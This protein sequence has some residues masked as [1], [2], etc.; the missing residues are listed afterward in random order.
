MTSSNGRTDTKHVGVP[1][2]PI[3][4]EHKLN[5]FNI[6]VDKDLL[7]KHIEHLI[8]LLNVR[9]TMKHTWYSF[10]FELIINYF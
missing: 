3:K 4:K 6:P 7:G 8:S 2:V 9:L 10:R 5:R 1:A